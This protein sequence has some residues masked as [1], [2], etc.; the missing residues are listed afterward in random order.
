ML[1]FCGFAAM[2]TPR[3]ERTITLIDV[4]AARFHAKNPVPIATRR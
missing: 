1:L 4:S 3:A 2:M